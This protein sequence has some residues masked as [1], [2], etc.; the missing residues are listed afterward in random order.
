MP[1]GGPRLRAGD[2]RSNRCG[3][4][5]KERRRGLKLNQEQLC[6]RLEDM[7]DGAWAPDRL[8]VLRIERGS[9]IVSDVEV[10]ALAQALECEACW[11]LL[12]AE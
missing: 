9:R 1:L 10:V 5:V 12:G 8:E 6:A 7:T 11:L 4:R 2:G 3:E